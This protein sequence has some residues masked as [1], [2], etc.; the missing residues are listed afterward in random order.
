MTTFQ[1]TFFQYNRLLSMELR[2]GWL[3]DWDG[4][5]QFASSCLRKDAVDMSELVSCLLVDR[6]LTDMDRWLMDC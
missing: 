2:C 1:T 4:V 3:S 6:F 5:S